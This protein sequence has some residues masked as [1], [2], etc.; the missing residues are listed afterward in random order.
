METRGL[1]R[2]FLYRTDGGEIR[3]AQVLENVYYISDEGIKKGKRF[4]GA[5]VGLYV[6]AGDRDCHGVFRYFEYR[7]AVNDKRGEEYIREGRTCRV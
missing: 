5:M 6:Y 7:V 4:T 3:L 2:R 1:E